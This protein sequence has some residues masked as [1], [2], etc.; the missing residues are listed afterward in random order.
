MKVLNLNQAID[1]NKLQV[2][3]E[4]KEEMETVDKLYPTK[5]SEYYTN[6]ALKNNAVFLQAFPSKLELTEGKY[7]EKDPLSEEAHQII[8]GFVHKYA[9]K[10]I[11]LTTHNCFM[12][13]R[14]CTRKRIMHSIY[15]PVVPDYKRIFGYLQEHT[16][17]NDILLT[18]GDV[19]TLTNEALIDLIGH[20]NKIKHINTIRLGTRAPVTCPDRIEPE[21]FQEIGKFQ[22]VWVN[23]QFNHPCELTRESLSACRII[24]KNGI[25]ICNQTVILRGINDNYEILKELCLK[26]VHNR[27][28]PY[29]LYQC[30][31]VIGVSHF[32]TNPR[33]GAEVVHRLRQELPGMAVPRYIIDT[34]ND[35]GKIIAEFSNVIAFEEDKVQLSAPNGNRCIMQYEVNSPKIV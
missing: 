21:L 15:R 20:L 2:S 13:C 5:I 9:N 8:P 32:I 6:L 24:Q 35:N 4:T 16:E 29:Y 27:I 30:D 1:I 28:I 23:T 18:G 31:N 34:Q 11:I 25:P 22:N 17:I 7:C 19:L 10:A 26:L 3:P 14:H 33:F 12:N